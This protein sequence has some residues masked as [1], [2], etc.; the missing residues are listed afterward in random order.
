MSSA[1]AKLILRMLPLASVLGFGTSLSLIKELLYWLGQQAPN[2]RSARPPSG[3]T[4]SATGVEQ[5]SVGRG[6]AGLH[7]VAGRS[8][9]I[10]RAGL[11]E[12][13]APHLGTPAGTPDPG[14]GVQR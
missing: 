12:R 13:H 10:C 11:G 5:W 14:G 2:C 9:Q 7:P 6:L 4:P 1:I 3:D 8:P